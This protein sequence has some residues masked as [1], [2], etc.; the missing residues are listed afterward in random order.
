LVGL[1][2]GADSYIGDLATT[3][4]RP[5]RERYD[6]V[7]VR[8]NLA[9]T[10]AQWNHLLPPIQ[11]E[12]PALLS[13]AGQPH[14]LAVCREAATLRGIPAGLPRLPMRSLSSDLRDE[15]RRLLAELGEL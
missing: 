13:D 12:Y 6:T 7:G 14:W 5:L 2:V 10:R 1:A 8:R 4:P 9:S 3:V 11:F 15:V